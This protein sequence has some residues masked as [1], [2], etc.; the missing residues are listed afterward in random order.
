MRTV[1]AALVIVFTVACAVSSAQNGGTF[2]GSMGIGLTSAQS[3]FSSA[4]TGFSGGSGFGMEADLQYYLWRGFSIGGLINYMR[5]GSTYQSDRGRLSFN[6]SQLGGFAKM[7]FKDLSDGKI[8]L[9]SGGGSFTPNAHY[10]VPD[11]SSDVAAAKSGYFAYGGIGLTSQTDS[12]VIYELEARYNMARADYTLD[13]IT[14]NV[15][16]FVYVGVKLSFASK[17][18]EAPPRY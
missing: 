16:D 4:T 2:V 15:W 17:G 3:D 13:T 11:N 9:T 5:F 8:Y 18:K 10:Y 1:L 6:F 7:N 14:S 12:R